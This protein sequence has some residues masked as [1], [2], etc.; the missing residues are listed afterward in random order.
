MKCYSFGFLMIVA[1]MGLLFGL[2]KNSDAMDIDGA[3]YD[4]EPIVQQYH[5]HDKKNELKDTAHAV[6][7]DELKQK[8]IKHKTQSK[9]QDQKFDPHYD[10]F[11]FNFFKL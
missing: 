9:Q 5:D 1:L 8:Q 7:P 11:R 4:L 6:F 3:W 2:T 10:R